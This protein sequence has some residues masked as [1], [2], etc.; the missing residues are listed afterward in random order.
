MLDLFAIL[1]ILQQEEMPVETRESI[2]DKF[3]NHYTVSADEIADARQHHQKFLL[4]E[5]KRLR[6]KAL[7][8]EN[9]KTVTE[10]IKQL[11]KQL[12]HSD[13]D[14]KV[15]LNSIYKTSK[16]K[17]KA[18]AVSVYN[19]ETDEVNNFDSIKEAAVFIKRGTS[20]VSTRLTDSKNKGYKPQSTPYFVNYTKDFVK[21]VKN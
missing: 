16:K 12:V 8:D 10:A 15:V 6:Q 3:E 17:T 7:D 4:E 11:Q 2:I 18:V 20:G 19:C 9:N 1:D 14:P 21:P 13:P 5:E